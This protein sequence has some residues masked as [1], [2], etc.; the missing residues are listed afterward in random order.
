MGQK[1]FL[2][3]HFCITSFTF[4]SAQEKPYLGAEIRTKETFLYGKFEVR[5]KPA[6]ASGIINGFFTFYDEPDFAVKWNELDIEILGRYSNE[7]QFNAI[8]GNHQMHEKRIILPFNPHEDFH[9][10]S[11]SWTPEYISWS[12]D[13]NEVY[14][15]TEDYVKTI[16]RPQKLMVNLWA[17]TSKEWAGAIDASKMPLKAEYDFINIYTYNPRSTDTFLLQRTDKFDSFDKDFWEPAF[18]TFE[19]NDCIF[20]S[21]NVLVESG[22]LRL[23]LTKP[24]NEDEELLVLSKLIKSVECF[25]N[26]NKKYANALLVKVSFYQA[27]NKSLTKSDFFHINKGTIVHQWFDFDRMYLLLYVE[28]ISADQLKRSVLSYV[29]EGAMNVRY[30]QQIK[31]R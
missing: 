8:V 10:Y 4:L 22:Y 16:N 13:E 15:Q 6:Q 24:V 11:F 25:P 28:G 30:I 5:M 21:E 31:I 26:T 1:I 27:V 23:L 3:V 9:L 20:T 29:P 19:G 14:R 17:S 2:L 12:V 7:I 18:H